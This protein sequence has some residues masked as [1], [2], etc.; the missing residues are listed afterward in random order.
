PGPLPALH[1]R[2][3]RRE[4]RAQL[5]GERGTGSESRTDGEG[6]TIRLALSC[7]SLWRLWGAALCIFPFLVFAQNPPLGNEARVALVVG[8]GNYSFNRLE[9][10]VND[11]VD[12]GAALR[13]LGFETTVLIDPS[14]KQVY[15]SLDTLE[16]SLGRPNSVGL[17]FFAGHGAQV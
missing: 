8:I 12:L 9:N 7:V 10:P 15:E 13:R 3:E 5:C 16:R 2:P 17:F 14:R 11:A 6:S 4:D 1:V